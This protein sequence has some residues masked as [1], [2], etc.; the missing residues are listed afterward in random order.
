MPKTTKLEKLLNNAREKARKL[1][2]KDHPKLKKALEYS[3]SVNK[4]AYTSIGF[5]NFD[6]CVYILYYLFYIEKLT[7]VQMSILFGIPR[8]TVISEINRV[9]FNFGRRHKEKDG[10]GKTEL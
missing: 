8:S 4:N 10:I 5:N 1:L 9:K 6:E 3:K 7:T 2:P